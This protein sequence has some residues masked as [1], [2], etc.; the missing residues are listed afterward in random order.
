MGDTSPLLIERLL[1]IEDYGDSILVVVS[2]C[3]LIG[4]SS[5]ISKSFSAIISLMSSLNISIMIIVSS[6]SW[7][8][9]SFDLFIASL[10]ILTTNTISSIFSPNVTYYTSSNRR[11]FKVFSLLRNPPQI[12][13]IPSY[14]LYR[15]RTGRTGLILLTTHLPSKISQRTLLVV[16]GFGQVIKSLP[17]PAISEVSTLVC[18]FGG[19]F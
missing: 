2:H 16:R 6:R 15:N 9:I 14:K 5:Y 19:Y 10:K 18:R 17:K 11:F 4:D 12:L 7:E 8:G 3:P 1:H 13:M